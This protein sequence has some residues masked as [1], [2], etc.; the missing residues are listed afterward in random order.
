MKRLL[1]ILSLVILSSCGKIFNKYEVVRNCSGTYLK[2]GTKHFNVC[3]TN[4]LI[5]YSNG[6]K[7]KVK[8]DKVESCFGLI[9]PNSCT[10][11]FKVE[12]KIDITSIDD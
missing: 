4:K 9:E 3:N 8:F 7:I 2:K 12:Y 11:P 5:N 6:A 10:V 1:F